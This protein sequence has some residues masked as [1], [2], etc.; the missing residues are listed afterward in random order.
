M[1][2]TIQIEN[3]V[4]DQLD[5]LKK[6]HRESYNELLK[7]IID[8]L[9]SNKNYDESSLIETVEVLSDFETMKNLTQ[10]LEEFEKGKTFSWKKIKKENKLNV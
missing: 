1:S 6:H 7:R 2:T 3:N 9:N 10:A 8:N 5:L 4:K